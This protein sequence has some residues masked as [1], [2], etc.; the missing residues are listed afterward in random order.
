MAFTPMPPAE[1]D[2]TYTIVI[3]KTAVPYLEAFYQLKKL[4]GETKEQYLSRCLVTYGKDYY[5]Q[6]AIVEVATNLS[7][8]K[9][10]ADA[11]TKALLDSI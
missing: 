2:E 4:D 3:P 11:Q 6:M 8:A 10:S 7:L 1:N 5:K 9:K